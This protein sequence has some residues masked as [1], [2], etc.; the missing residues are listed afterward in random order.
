MREKVIVA[1]DLKGFDNIVRLV[2]KLDGA[3]WFKV[4]AVNFTA[5]GP[6]LISELKKRNKKVFLDLKYHDIPNT[7]KAATV[8]ACEL[9]VDMITVHASGGV[10]MMR[11]AVE[12]LRTKPSIEKP[13]IVLA[14]TVLTSMDDEILKESLFVDLS[15]GQ[16]VLKLA[17]NAYRA[18]V[19]GVIA[20]PKEIKLI[21][22]TFGNK[23]RIITPGI[24]P[25]WAAKGDQKR[26]TTPADAVKLGADSIVVGR[27]IYENSDPERAFEQ[28]VKEMEVVC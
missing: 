12:A 9:G 28:I 23:L 8:A 15:V 19:D 27:P 10:D 1:L 25:V 16:M 3:V 20:S 14:V 24:R 5:Y 13:P 11:A 7:V 22:D 6:R 18:K 26:I 2:D 4:G 17:E 21:K